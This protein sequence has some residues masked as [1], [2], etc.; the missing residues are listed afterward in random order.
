[1]LSIL[2]IRAVRVTHPFDSALLQKLVSSLL[3][4][5]HK[6]PSLFP[7]PT[8]QVTL[9]QEQVFVHPS[10]DAGAPTEDPSLR[11]TL[12]LT[13]PKRRA[14]KELKVVLIGLC[15]VHTPDWPYESSEALRKELL[16][17]LEGE[18]LEAG[19]Y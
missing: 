18:V 16:V 15:D 4:L 9:A 17:D 8:L 13:L 19:S 10:A 3:L 5:P 6:M 12:V 11:G 7:T 14:V 1:M 2:S